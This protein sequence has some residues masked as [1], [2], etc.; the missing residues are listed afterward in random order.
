MA[1]ASYEAPKEGVAMDAEYSKKSKHAKVPGKGW[2][3]HKESGQRIIV[4][5]DPLWRN[6]QAQAF[7]RLGFVF[8]RDATADE[9]KTLPELAADTRKA[10]EGTLKGL[11]ARLDALEGVAQENKS[12]TDEVA[13][14]REKLEAE[15]KAR[16]EAEKSAADAQKQI[17]EAGE[18]AREAGRKESE[19][20]AKKAA[21]AEVKKREGASGDTNTK[22]T[23]N[24]KEGSK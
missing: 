22:V 14:L 5:D 9:I 4:Q 13:A 6:T 7:A 10:E 12:L 23:E 11:S 18:K 24:Q 16:E 3:V 17:E 20:A 8:E 2:Y 1:E 21:E 15:Q 19:E